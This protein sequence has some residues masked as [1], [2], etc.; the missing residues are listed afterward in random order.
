MKLSSF[1]DHAHDDEASRRLEQELQAATPAF[2]RIVLPWLP[3]DRRARIYEVACGPGIMLRWLR[4]HGYKNVSGSDLSA[5]QLQ[6]ARAAGFPVKVADSV[7][8]LRIMPDN[9]I[10]C[11][12]GF[13]F[14]EHLAKEIMLDFIAE[15]NRVLKPGGRLILLGPNGDTP[16]VGRAL[17]NDITHQWALTSY[18]FGLL[19]KR[20]G[21]TSIEFKDGAMPSIRRWRAVKLPLIWAAQ[22]ILRLLFRIAT[23][24]R[25][26]YFSSSIYLCARK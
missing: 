2:N 18:S 8:E 23:M 1:Y 4:Q 19:L 24:E 25:I 13:N 6:L 17:F 9:T 20:A 21:F 3:S 7:E 5:R 10:D 16:V 14:Y 15:A 26:E 12:I 11:I 22:W